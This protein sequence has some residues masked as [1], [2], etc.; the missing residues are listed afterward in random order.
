MVGG[1]GY[2]M[3]SYEESSWGRKKKNYENGPSG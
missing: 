2:I 1:T 3:I